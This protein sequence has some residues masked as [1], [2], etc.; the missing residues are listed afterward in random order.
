MRHPNWL[1]YL[2][3]F[4]LFFPIGFWTGNQISGR[5]R[6]SIFPTGFKS[7]APSTSRINYP[8]PSDPY[9]N[10]PGKDQR[11]A[12]VQT[13]T[14]TLLL[15]V[16]DLKAQHPKLTSAWLLIQPKES[17][18]LIFVPIFQENTP[19]L[20]LITTFSLD[21]GELSRRFTKALEKRNLLWHSFIV[22]DQK[23]QKQLLAKGDGFSNHGLIPSNT[24]LDWVC[25]DL[26]LQPQSINALKPLISDH[27][28]ANIELES[29]LGIWQHRLTTQPNVLCEFPTLAQ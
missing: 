16:D 8:L 14:N 19:D 26:P 12:G 4:S 7:I 23:A 2:I 9:L 5:N 11:S 10:Q 3:L 29:A 20:D 17:L 28:V 24:V 21:G 6:N 15:F 22:L 18:R 27:L 1:S 13:Q 25:K